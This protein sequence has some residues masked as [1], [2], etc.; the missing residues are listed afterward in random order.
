MCI[1]LD[2]PCYFE[3]KRNLHFST[4]TR[5]VCETSCKS[6][7]YNTIYGILRALRHERW[8]LSNDLICYDHCF[9]S[10]HSLCTYMSPILCNIFGVKPHSST[11]RIISCCRQY[12]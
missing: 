8:R 12:S 1:I 2:M 3:H 11:Y 6:F 9:V 5:C 4:Y 10:K 7:I